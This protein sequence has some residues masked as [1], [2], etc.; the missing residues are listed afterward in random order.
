MK[1]NAIRVH[2][3]GDIERM[4][5]ESVDLPPPKPA[6]ARVRHEAIGVNYIDTYHRSGLY[7][8]PTPTGIGVEAAG[9][10]DEIGSAV[11]HLEVG[12]RVAYCGGPI[13]AYAQASNVP[14]ARLI[15]LPNG[16]S[17]DAAAAMLLKGLTVQ[18]LFRQ[19]YV[20]KK[21]ETILFH[22]AAGGVGLLAAQW[23]K[24]LGVVMIGTV[25]SAE[26]AKLAMARGCAHVINYSNENVPARVAEI[27]GGRKVPVVY[28]GVGKDTFM[29]SLDSLAPRGLLVSFG[30]ASGPVTGVDLGIL[31]AKGSLYVTRPTLATYTATTEMLQSAADELFAL[32][33]SGA[34]TPDITRHYPLA[35]AQ[36]AHRALQSRGTVGSI[37]LT[38]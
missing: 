14:A 30:N 34:I 6:E 38:P 1:I 31:S 29:A 23:A 17:S 8:L 15:K 5:F 21:D 18:Y 33:A 37:L 32:V 7:K 19:T 10:V 11:T 20:L 25:S 27:T 16:V 36:D 12:D 26:K 22:A 28:D 13:G 9:I 4:K 2:E 35:Q 24:H 3:Q